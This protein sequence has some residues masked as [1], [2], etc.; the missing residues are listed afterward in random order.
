MAKKRG[1]GEGT[2]P[3]KRK[4]GLWCAQY[5]VHTAEG[6]RRK[7]L[8]GKTRQEVA[9]KLAKALS[10]RDGGTF[11]DAANQTRGEFMDRWLQDSVRDT[12][13]PRTYE[14]HEELI[15]LHIRP[16]LGRLALKNLSPAHVQAFYRDRLDSGLSPA[17]VQNYSHVLPTMQNG[18]ARALEDMLR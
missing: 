18:A 5:T 7:T 2:T 15:R 9:T 10:D 3:Y 14:R 16:A 6:R 4:N 12:V 1:N 11:F 17:T 8:Y 13:R